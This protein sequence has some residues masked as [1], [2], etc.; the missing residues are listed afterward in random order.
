MPAGARPT[1]Y[2][3][4]LDLDPSRD[5]FR[6]SVTIGLSLDAP[7][8]LVW[9]NAT[10]LTI[11]EAAVTEG[12]A[13][14]VARIVAGGDD[15][16]GLAF[17]SPLPAGA[18]E[19]R[20][21]YAG[22]VADN[23]LAG[24]FRQRTGGRAYLFTHF[25][26][27]DARRAFPCFDEP[28]YKVPWQLTL[29]VP[30]GML[31]AS[32]TPIAA[33]TRASGGRVRLR[34]EETPPLPS[35]LVAFTVGPFDV[36]DG[37]RIGAKKIPFRVLSPH[38]R[39]AEATG[40]VAA[41]PRLLTALEDYFGSP[42]PY[43]KLDLVSVP[44]FF[45]AMEN[46]GLITFAERLLIATP[47]LAT[48]R[49]ERSFASVCAHELAHQ[50]FGGLVTMAWWDDIWLNE[51]FASW[52]ET[53]VVDS[54]RPDWQGRTA[55]A[56]ARV[57]SMDADTLMTARR[58]RQPIETKGDIYSAFDA[59]T[60]QKGESVLRMFEAWLGEETFRRGVRHY[61]SSHAGGSASADDFLAD[62]GEVAG[63]DVAKP[64][65]TFLDQSGIPL[66]TVTASCDGP[67]P[68]LHI[69]QERYLPI[70]ARAAGDEQ[71]TWEIPVCFELAAGT[72]RTRHCE[73]IGST[74]ADVDLE[75]DSPCP[76][77][78]DANAGDHGYYLV[79]R[80]PDEVEAILSDP[81]LP[82]ARRV[83]LLA[84]VDLLMRGGRFP[85][86]RALKLAA[87]F[88]G[89]ADRHV[90]EECLS[91]ARAPRAPHD[92]LLTPELAPAYRRFLREHFVGR[93]RSVGFASVDG[94]PDD[95]RL[96]RPQLLR[97]ALVEAEDPE[98]LA[99]AAGL[100]TGWLAN[101]ASLD[102]DVAGPVLSATV[103]HGDR[104]LFDEIRRQAIQTEDDHDRRRLLSALT[105][106]P[107]PELQREALG[108]L[109]SD[110]IPP[111][112][113]TT[114]LRASGID[115]QHAQIT[116]DFIRAHHD[117]LVARLPRDWGAYLPDV[118]NGFCDLEHQ[119]AV[120]EFFAKRAPKFP[121]GDRVLAEVL[122]A[123]GQ[124]AAWKE[125]QAGSLR[126]LLAL[127]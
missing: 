13:S 72:S 106:F 32:N 57:Y 109:L 24:V 11:D 126:E 93:A 15:F 52:M 116:L 58:I 103:R 39:A 108:L 113:A 28:S 54:Y 96:L 78:I 50:W 3:V 29:T 16:V 73:V 119:A 83:G 51:A 4:E 71:P 102:G 19:A 59:I 35:Y 122:E 82:V 101:R 23:E 47:E 6:G 30:R 18:A 94:E 38:E 2:R 100:A 115:E 85:I 90:T 89:D 117:E 91:I 66:V 42:Y 31:A 118:G 76:A 104:K 64:F 56:A 127:P 37:G 79:S 27:L 99:T 81:S 120:R 125:A 9:V 77:R 74:A 86:G 75:A 69:G 49:H 114:L 25:E 98:L 84:E 43:A 61:L 112:K 68:V 65:G 121:G 92:H 22:K 62:L 40:A 60:Y 97:L 87:R 33:S 46:P 8:D 14:H 53:K 21:T 1:H 36:A 17:D 44:R 12:G 34:F 80:T 5:V 124:C 55:T 95:I 110:E 123:I 111:H 105:A 20:I 67:H 7:T 70:G 48:P 45:G 41:T 88:V 63:R 10:D 107:S 26:S